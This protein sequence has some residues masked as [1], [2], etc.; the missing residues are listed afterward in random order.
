MSPDAAIQML[1]ILVVDDN[2]DDVILL[3]ESL[4]DHPAVRVVQVAR[5]G[6][7][8]LAYLRREGEHANAPH[9]GLV[10]LDINMPR[11]NG[12][13]VLSAMK[14]DPLLRAIPVVMLTTSY[15]EDDVLDAYR[16]GA[17]SFVSKPVS[18]ERLKMMAG[19]FVTYWS[20]VARLP[21]IDRNNT[22]TERSGDRAPDA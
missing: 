21:R 4:R 22:A 2:E 17:C 5:D 14:E 8:A 20:C 11:R 6:D 9:P 19:H 10:L 3:Q 18:F 7:E 12:F 13:E 1:H 15:R 16:G